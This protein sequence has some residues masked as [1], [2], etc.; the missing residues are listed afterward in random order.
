MFISSREVLYKYLAD[1]I[2]D[3]TDLFKEGKESED[4]DIEYSG[5]RIHGDINKNKLTLK[6]TSQD[7][8]KK[9]YTFEYEE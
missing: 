2:W 3:K 9:E 4:I 6:V 5:V 1:E 8:S 7:S